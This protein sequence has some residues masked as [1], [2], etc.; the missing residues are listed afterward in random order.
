VGP[1]ESR[2]GSASGP[3]SEPPPGD[4]RGEA[5]VAARLAGSKHPHASH[6]RLPSKR[7]SDW[8]PPVPGRCRPCTAGTARRA[9]TRGRRGAPDSGPRPR[10]GTSGGAAPPPARWRRAA[11]CAA[12]ASRSPAP[13]GR[14]FCGPGAGRAGAGAGRTAGGAGGAGGW[15]PP[16]SGRPVRGEGRGWGL[17]RVG[18]GDRPAPKRNCG[19]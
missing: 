1:S 13:G 18:P 17:G 7:V 19:Y 6:Q 10:R 2:V 4:V 8:P 14:G 11:S 9:R 3:L 5:P 12:A 16:F 15:C